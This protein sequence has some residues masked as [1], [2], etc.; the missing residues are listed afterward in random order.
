MTSSNQRKEFYV[1]RKA[2]AGIIIK[3]NIWHIDKHINGKRVCKSTKPSNLEEAEKFLAKLMED[4]R[5]AQNYSVR[6]ERILSEAAEKYL[7]E[8]SYKGALG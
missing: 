6:K 7:S 3:N 5:Q 8:K 2:S 1:G 4:S